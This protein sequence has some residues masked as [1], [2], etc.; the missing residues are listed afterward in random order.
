MGCRAFLRIS[1]IRSCWSSRKMDFPSV[2]RCRS[3]GSLEHLDQS[4]A[5]LALEEPKDPPD[6]LQGKSLAAQF[7]DD[8]DLD[9][10]GR[11]IHAAMPLMPRGE[12]TLALVPPL[13]LPQADAA[14]PGDI[15]RNKFGPGWG[16]RGGSCGL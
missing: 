5:H 6:L 13:H 8:R 7:G 15:A 14:D 12:T 4:L 2:T 10:F 3:E 9:H 11:E 1:M 16:A